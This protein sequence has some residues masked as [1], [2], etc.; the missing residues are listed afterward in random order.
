VIARAVWLLYFNDDTPYWHGPYFS[1]QSAL[2][3]CEELNESDEFASGVK[4]H[5][6]G[7]Y[8]R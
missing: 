2:D 8:V 4:L 7:P 3:E 1:Y 6:E 5:V